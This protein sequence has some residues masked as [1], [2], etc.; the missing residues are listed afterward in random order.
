M[1]ARRRLKERRL[2]K[3]GRP[4]NAVLDLR[5]TEEDFALLVEIAGPFGQPTLV[6]RKVLEDWLAVSVRNGP[7]DRAGGATPCLRREG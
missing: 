5:I 4:L 1:E 6:A 7:K 2:R 3:V